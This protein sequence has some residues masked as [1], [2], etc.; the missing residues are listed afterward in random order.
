MEEALEEERPA[1]AASRPEVPEADAQEQGQPLR[2]SAD[3]RP[4]MGD[5]VPEADAIEQARSW[6]EGD[7]DEERG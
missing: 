1:E 3:D 2:R 7:E 5:E 6:G 4:R